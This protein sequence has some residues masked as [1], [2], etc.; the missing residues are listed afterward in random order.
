MTLSGF[1]PLEDLD[2]ESQL[3]TGAFG[4]LNESHID[5]SPG[6]LD[7]YGRKLVTR[8]T[9]Q[10]TRVVPATPFAREDAAPREDVG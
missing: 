2:S 8:P 5:S 9:P 7:V 6:E 10:K 1:P 3:V 4:T